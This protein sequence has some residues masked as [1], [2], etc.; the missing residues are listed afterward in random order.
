MCQK[1][2]IDTHRP[3]DCMQPLPIP[4]SPWIDLAIDFI[5]GLPYFCG[6]N[7]ITSGRGHVN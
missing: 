5:E 1:P 7:C 3:Y 2:K 4:T 6:C